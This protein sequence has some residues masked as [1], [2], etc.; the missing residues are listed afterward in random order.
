MCV[1]LNSILARNRQGPWDEPPI[2]CFTDDTATPKLLQG[3]MPLTAALVYGHCH[4]IKSA[5]SIFKHVD[6]DIILV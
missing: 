5:F 6:K 1:L 4:V 2:F 3:V